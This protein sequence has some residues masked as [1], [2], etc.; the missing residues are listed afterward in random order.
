LKKVI[1]FLK[2]GDAE[3]PT[4]TSN[5]ESSQSIHNT[6]SMER[7]FDDRIKEIFYDEIT[8]KRH[9]LTVSMEKASF[10]YETFHLFKKYQMAVHH[11]SET[12]I[13]ERRYKRF[14]IDSP[15]EVIIELKVR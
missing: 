2:F 12:Q 10:T 7:S 1:H 3:F 9:H 15:L 14:L 8:E 6:R 11:E 13:S 4:E 5:Q